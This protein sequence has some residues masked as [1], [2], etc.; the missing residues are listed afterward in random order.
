M[1]KAQTQ[2]LPATYISWTKSQ[3]RAIK[4]RVSCK[5]ELLIVLY[6]LLSLVG[7]AGLLWVGL[8]LSSLVGLSVPS[9]G[10]SYFRATRSLVFLTGMNRLLGL[11]QDLLPSVGGGDFG[12][13]FSLLRWIAWL[14]C[15]GRIW[16]VASFWA[17]FGAPGSLFSWETEIC[18]CATFSGEKSLG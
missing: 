8:Q 12:A 5:R 9:V 13:L 14:M 1:K 4:L 7:S 2:C 15:V 6:Q 18:D 3:S 16:L 10:R 11:L 17:D